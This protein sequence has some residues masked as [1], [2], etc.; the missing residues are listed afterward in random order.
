MEA[1]ASAWACERFSEFLIGKDLHIKTDYKAL[2]LQTHNPSIPADILTK[3]HE[4]HLGITKC[5]EKVKHQY[6]GRASAKKW[7]ID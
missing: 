6:G 7:L 2:V 5:R 1:L 4:G 3:L